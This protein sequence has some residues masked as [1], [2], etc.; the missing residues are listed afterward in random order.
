MDLSAENLYDSA[1]AV[2]SFSRNPF[3]P[4]IRDLVLGSWIQG[5]DYFTRRK[6]GTPNWLLMMTRR[7]KAMLQSEEGEEFIAGAGDVLL[8][9]PGFYQDYATHEDPGSW[10]FLWAHFL[11]LPHWDFLP[12]GEEIWTGLHRIS[13][14]EAE[15]QQVVEELLPAFSPP[16]KRRDLHVDYAAQC[17]ERVFLILRDRPVAGEAHMDSRIQTVL[18]ELRLHPEHDHSVE[19]LANIASLSPSRFAHLF[20]EQCGQSPRAYQEQLRLMQAAHLLR[21][22]HLSIGDIAQNC[23]FED[24]FYFSRRFRKEHGLSPR[25]FRKQGLFWE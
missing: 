16:W 23:G 22:S 1:M 10:E 15:M 13:L 5:P 19:E 9:R 21:G 17:L 12:L 8:Y 18:R 14:E 7:G 3:Q 11:P 4:E 24:A 6:Q 2:A 25:A 20:R